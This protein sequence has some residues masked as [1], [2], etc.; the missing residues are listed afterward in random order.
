MDDIRHDGV[1]PHVGAWIETYQRR[2]QQRLGH[3]AP[4]VG[5]WIET[6]HGDGFL[7]HTFA[8]HPM[9]VR[10]LK[11]FNL[12]VA[13][14]ICVSHPMWVRGLKLEL[15]HEHRRS[16]ESHPMWVRGLKLIGYGHAIRATMVAPHVGAW[17]ET[18]INVLEA[19]KPGRT[20]CGC[21]D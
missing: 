16:P 21:V 18:A 7:S 17:I 15:E 1:A 4:H 14:S 5:A 9:W 6:L 11:L 3:V 10:G 2:H 13:L 8:S 12:V 20:P 19:N